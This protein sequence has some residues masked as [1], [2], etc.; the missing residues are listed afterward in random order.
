MIKSLLKGLRLNVR[1]TFIGKLT[2]ST[3]LYVLPLPKLTC[4]V[5]HMVPGFYYSN[6]KL[7]SFFELMKF[8][9]Y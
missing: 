5:F 7:R 9:I 6:F 8:T 3:L 4:N 1:R 2:P